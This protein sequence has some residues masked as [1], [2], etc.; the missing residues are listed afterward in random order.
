MTE[1]LA[2]FAPLAIAV[3]EAT[4]EGTVERAA[5]I[6]IGILETIMAGRMPVEQGMRAADGSSQPA[7]QYKTTQDLL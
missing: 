6:N 1:Q 5:R 7:F 2:R 4:G 3:P